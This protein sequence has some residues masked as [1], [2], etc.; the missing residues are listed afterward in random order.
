MRLYFFGDG[1]ADGS[2][3]LRALLGS[4]GAELAEMA[5]LGVPVPAGF[6]L[7]TEICQ[8]IATHGW[9][10]AIEALLRQG[11]ARLE[12]HTGKRFGDP[13]QP[14]LVSVRAGAPRPLP[15]C[16]TTVLNIGMR[17]ESI[18]GLADIY[19]SE[20]F[21]WQTLLRSRQDF[22]ELVQQIDPFYFEEELDEARRSFAL[23][24][25]DPWT[26]EA[27]Q[28][29][30]QRFEAMPETWGTDAH[31]QDPYL[32][33]RHA[34]EAA[35]ASLNTPR[36]RSLRERRGN[37]EKDQVAV[38]IQAMVFG[39]ADSQSGTGILW[40]RNRRTGAPGF[41]GDFLFEAQGEDVLDKEHP[42]FSIYG[43]KSLATELPAIGERLKRVARLLENHYRDMQQIEFTVEHGELWVLQT[44]KARR[45]FE[46]SLQVAVDLVAEGL[47]TKNDAVRRVNPERIRD[48][49]HP[50]IERN[51]DVPAIARGIPTSPGAAS[52]LAV[53]SAQEAERFAGELNMAVIL[54][55]N[56]T[57]PDDIRALQSARGVVTARGG[58]TSH[59]AVVTRQ[60]G[61]PSIVGCDALLINHDQRTATLGEHTIRQGDTLTIDGS[62]GEIFHGELPLRPPEFSEAWHQIVSWA[63]E[64]KSIAIYANADS[65]GDA[66]LARQ[67]GAEGI[68]LVRTEH[69][70]F[71]PKRIHRMQEVILAQNQS[72]RAKA[73][74]ALQPLQTDDFYGILRA[75]EGTPVTI[76][77]LDP[78]LHEFLP[79]REE[80][81]HAIGNEL[82]LSKQEVARIAE[83]LR[84]QNPMLGHRGCRLAISWPEIYD[85]QA[86]ALFEAMKRAATNGIEYQV[87][88]LIPLVSDPLEFKIVR[89]RILALYAPWAEDPEMP[90]RPQIGSM[91]EVA[92]A[93]LLADEIAKLADFISFGTN[94][95]TQSVYGLSRDDAS[96][97]LPAYLDAGI[98]QNDPFSVLDIRGVGW[99]IEMA[100]KKARGANPKIRIGVCGEQGSDARSVAWL[101]NGV[102]DYIS[103]SPYR[104]PI[105]RMAAGRAAASPSGG[106]QNS[107][108]H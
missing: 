51:G 29:A 105:A 8:T 31:I 63:D 93:C 72:Q 46:A 92:R 4:K 88:I 103:C 80:D 23:R 86:V 40:T 16:L 30:Y 17:R 53:F 34:I 36:T 67:L 56:D 59:A 42:S 73:L 27:L 32:Q 14:L 89:D 10:D 90:E 37:P 83:N 75:A 12:E 15:G 43:D 24:P 69:M 35:I 25:E 107:A 55:K 9:N 99:F 57:A 98:M 47:I 5:R 18:C 58:M 94:D 104:V 70:F 102:V 44:R 97:F 20:L 77:L 22:G 78:P 3:A 7:S 91:I 28:K 64:L 106:A 38:N 66:R 13:Q 108:A 19:G 54:I 82:G 26:I 76:R 50:T 1:H 68:G 45:N 60:M 74:A 87:D 101:Q 95:L 52:G 81:L 100:V 11:I 6:T 85:M 21:A 71:D 84:E 33:L 79:H 96:T 41:D 49:L 48:L 65:A 62:T 39:N 61:K 2:G